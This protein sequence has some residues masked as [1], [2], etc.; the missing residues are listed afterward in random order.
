MD[1]DDNENA[2]DVD[3]PPGLEGGK[4]DKRSCSSMLDNV[5]N[6]GERPFG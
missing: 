6:D 1:G 3:G 2:N 4:K 5:N